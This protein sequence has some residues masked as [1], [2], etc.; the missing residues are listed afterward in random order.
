LRTLGVPFDRIGLHAYKHGPEWVEALSSHALEAA[1]Y[2]RSLG[3]FVTVGEFNWKGLTRLSPDARAKEFAAVYEAM[4]APRA[5]P[6]LFQFQFQETLSANPSIARKGI[7][8]YETLMLDRRPKP[9]AFELMRLIR[10]YAAPGSAVGQLDVVAPEAVLQSGQATVP[11]TLRNRTSHQLTITLHAAAYDGLSVRLLTP[12]RVMVPT[13]STFRGRVLLRLDST[14]ATGT[15]QWFL[16]AD[17]DGQTRW[18][19]GVVAQEGAPTFDP[20]PVLTGHVVYPQGADVVRTLRWRGPLTVAWGPAAPTLDVEMAYM[21][22]NTLESATGQPVTYMSTADLPDSLR[23]R[24][25]LIL[26]GT[27][28][29]NPL[30][31]WHSNADP[32]GLHT[33]VVRVSASQSGTRLLL[34]GRSTQAVQAAATDLV[35]RFWRH[36]KDAG[37]R[38][39]GMEPGAALGHPAEVTATTLP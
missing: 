19:W 38:I 8:H 14:A 2:A 28:R 1:G 30:I 29:S 23:H 31:D 9:G 35:L 27:P 3:K 16:R 20:K 12:E 22:A 17:F 6:E 33:G 5:I 21:V 34:T 7:R 24:G 36:A 11:F 18:G 26:V 4:L 39:T 37:I 15:Y 25:L 13:D 32:V 10:Q